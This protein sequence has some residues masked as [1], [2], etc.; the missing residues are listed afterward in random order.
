MKVI[1]V[2][3]KLIDVLEYGQ[4]YD[5]E[6]AKLFEAFNQF[7]NGYYGLINYGDDWWK[8]FN[9]DS[10]F[11][12]AMEE[13]WSEIEKIELMDVLEAIAK[14]MVG[15]YVNFDSFAKV[16]IDAD[17]KGKGCRHKGEAE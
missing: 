17:K 10:I 2:D 4:G 6:I 3:T 9:Q 15:T 11:D 13:E 12:K 1:D 5:D 16:V 8:V 7:R 14:L